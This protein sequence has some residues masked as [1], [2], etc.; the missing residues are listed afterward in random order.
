MGWG[1]MEGGQRI[2]NRRPHIP[3]LLTRWHAHAVGVC[4]CV[5]ILMPTQWGVSMCAYLD[6]HAVGCV[7]VCLS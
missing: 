6:A 7:N 2:S 5:P 1:A 4:Q 3:P